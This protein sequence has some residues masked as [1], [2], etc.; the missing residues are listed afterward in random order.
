MPLLLIA[1]ISSLWPA[2]VTMQANLCQTPKPQRPVF[3][4]RLIHVI[5]MFIYLQITVG[6]A[7]TSTESQSFLNYLRNDN[8]GLDTGE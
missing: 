2:S 8:S 7:G 5:C 4:S 6:E 3:A 1:K